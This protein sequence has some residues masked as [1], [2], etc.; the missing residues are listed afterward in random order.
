M[1]S[2]FISGEMIEKKSGPSRLPATNAATQILY[3]QQG[4]KTKLQ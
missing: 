1:S 2:F 4:L 3:I